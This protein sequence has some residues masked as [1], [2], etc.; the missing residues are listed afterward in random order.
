M[1]SVEP[2]KETISTSMPPSLNQPIF[3]AI[4]KGATE[5]LRVFE[6]H[7]TRTLVRASALVG[8]PR[9]QIKAPMTANLLIM[10]RP[11]RLFRQVADL[12]VKTGAES[13]RGSGTGSNPAASAR[14]EG[15]Q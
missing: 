1:H 5:M 9:A 2:P 8:A 12:G 14:A 15:S 13:S 10:S 11:S 3:V 7:A 6:H 4:A